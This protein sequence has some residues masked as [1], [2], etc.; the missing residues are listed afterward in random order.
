[1]LNK[2]PHILFLASWYPST[3]KPTHGVFIKQHA[4]A[5]SQ[6][7]KVSIAYAYARES[8]SE[9]IE[10]HVLNENV[11]EYKLAYKKSNSILKPI[12]HYWR[13]KKAYQILFEKIKQDKQAVTAIQLNV[14]FPV[15]ILWRLVKK[16]FNVPHTIVEHWSGYLPQDGNYNGMLKTYFTKKAVV[17]A[18]TIFYVSE[19]MRKAMLNHGLKGKYQL[20]YNVVNTS[21]FKL[22]ERSEKPLLVHI[23]SLVEREKN[24]SGTL[25]IIAQLQ[26]KQI[27][28]DTLI[29]GGSGNDLM[30][31]QELAKKL[32]LTSIQ[33]TGNLPPEQ[34][35]PH[36]Q[37]AWALLLFSHF[38]GM[39]VVALEALACGV[40]VFASKV[41]HL[42]EIINNTNGFLG[43]TPIEIVDALENNFQSSVKYNALSMHQ[44]VEENASYKSVGKQLADY[45]K[46]LS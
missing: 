7:A 40:P 32:Q 36:L 31:A 9:K 41:G 15:A 24:I 14:I 3:E 19:P 28:F 37:K 13:A 21:I 30:E 10:C 39:P 23:S 12:L 8:S 17:N 26:K 2:S 6:F 33:F 46:A 38:E 44:W 27:A 42:P 16:T 35:V 1:V 29:I 25:E 5:L 45:Y 18:S 11:I 4:L 43:E 22:G 34:V 20:V